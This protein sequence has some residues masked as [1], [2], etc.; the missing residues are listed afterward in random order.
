MEILQAGVIHGVCSF[1]LA[2]ISVL[3]WKV[4]MQVM[5]VFRHWVSLRFF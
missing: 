3:K 2:T 1:D 4:S 5:K